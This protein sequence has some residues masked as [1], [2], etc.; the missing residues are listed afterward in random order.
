MLFRSVLVFVSALAVLPST[1]VDTQDASVLAGTWQGTLVPERRLGRNRHV[2]PPPLPVM[3]IIRTTDDGA[4]SWTWRSAQANAVAPIRLAIDG[5][6][7]RISVPAW[8]G[9]WLGTLSDDDSTLD[10]KWRQGGV[11]HSH[12]RAR[13]CA[14]RRFSI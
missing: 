6:K 12:A 11:T 10:G 14:V 9:T 5:D 2:T 8:D 1:A 13:T 3:V 4:H 7:V